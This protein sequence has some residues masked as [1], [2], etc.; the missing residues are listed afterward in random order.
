LQAFLRGNAVCS[1]S[2]AGTGSKLCTFPKKTAITVLSASIPN[3]SPA[4][5]PRQNDPFFG[6]TNEKV[7]KPVARGIAIVIY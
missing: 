5:N 6:V 4:P 1:V 3:Y 2:L 7:K